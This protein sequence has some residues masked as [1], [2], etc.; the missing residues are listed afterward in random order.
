ME[1]GLGMDWAGESGAW[2]GGQTVWRVGGRTAAI[3]WSGRR[4][5]TRPW[6]GCGKEMGRRAANL[7]VVSTGGSFVRYLLIW[8][9]GA[10]RRGWRMRGRGAVAGPLA[11]ACTGAAHSRGPGDPYGVGLMA[12][13]LHGMGTGEMG[14][15]PSRSAPPGLLYRSESCPRGQLITPSSRPFQ[16]PPDT[17]WM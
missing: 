9:R 7:L 5:R 1:Q 12:E 6:H 17:R 15:R 14:G 3:R 13:S 10:F 2:I 8:G 4:G 16:G 11:A